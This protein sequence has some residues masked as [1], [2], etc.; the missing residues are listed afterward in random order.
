MTMPRPNGYLAALL[1]ASAAALAA[2]VA[3]RTTTDPHAG[4][5][6]T[7][8][9]SGGASS[10]G[11]AASSSSGGLDAAAAPS[12]PVDCGPAP[13]AGAPFSKQALL[14]AEADC[15]AWHAC[16]FQNAATALR[17]SVRAYTAAPSDDKK[18]SAQT[19]WRTAMNEWSKME[20]FRFGPVASKGVDQYHGRGIG[21]FV[22]PWPDVN[23][24][25]V[26]TQIV[27]KGYQQGWNVVLPSGRGLFALEYVFFYPNA[28]TQCLAN[29][30]AAQAWAK[31]SPADLAQ[32][33]NDY[34]NAVA[35][36]IVGLALEIRN[37]WA[38]AGESFERK[39]VAADGYGSEQEALNIV[40]WSLMYLEQEIKDLKVASLAG[41][42]LSPPNPETPFARIEIENI[43]TNLRAFRAV[44]QGC[45][46]D[47]QGLGFDDWL[48][49]AGHG[50][51]ATQILAELATAQA[52]ADAFPS[53]SQATETELAALYETIRPLS[54]LLKQSFMGS[55]SP[56]NLKLPATAASDTD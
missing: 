7:H 36:N 38:E 35:D 9:S 2:G 44:F 21:T 27:Q 34:A 51:L 31:T 20:L 5:G 22:S 39:L 1:S 47:G 6:T 42:S 40:A 17:T 50:A 43:R 49:E 26:E 32:A 11:V 14:A 46:A 30:Q 56:L 55:A 28:D 19:A 10:S 54:N 45:G 41:V 52:A 24:C 25:Q 16:G 33:K 13:S 29:S 8:A 12:G 3:C 53:F 4:R 18:L 37:V 23:R 48:T 15:A